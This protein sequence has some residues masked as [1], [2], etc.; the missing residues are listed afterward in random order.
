MTLYDG[1]ELKRR[2]VEAT[3]FA[4]FHEYYFSNF[5]ERGN[6]KRLGRML[7]APRSKFLNRALAQSYSEAAGVSPVIVSSRFIEIPEL[8]LIHGALDVNGKLASVLYFDDIAMG[9]FVVVENS[10]TSELK[11]MRFTVTRPSPGKPN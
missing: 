8:G 2:F 7:S 6:F 5:V 9:M 10:A 1:A 3:D 11:Y 4:A